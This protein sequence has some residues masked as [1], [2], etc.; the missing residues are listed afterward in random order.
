VIDPRISII[1]DRFRNVKAILCI[2][3]SKGGVGK[4]LFS[5][6]SA[7][8]LG[9]MNYSVGLLDLDFT[10]PSCHIVLGVNLEDYMPV[11]DKGI[12]P[13]KIHGIYFI[14]MAFYTRDEP[15]PLRGQ[16]VDE[17]FK[18]LL[19]ITRWPDIDFLIIDMPPGIRDEILNVFKFIPK[20]SFVVISTPDILSIKSAER[21]LK[22]LKESGVDVIGILCNMCRDNEKP[23]V[24]LAQKMGVMYLGKVGFY[25][26]IVAKIGEPAGLVNHKFSDDVKNIIIK[27]INGKA[28]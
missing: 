8:V 17:A 22:L 19:A 24:N 21:L 25:D 23:I 10:N 1:E 18:E 6:A 5:C 27:I 9:K 15:L 4:T 2:V 13:R 16:Y 3:S 20:A 26:D 14:T 28:T 7:L 12:V 11:E